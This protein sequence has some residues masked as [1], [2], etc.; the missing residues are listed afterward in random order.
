MSEEIINVGFT[1]DAD[2]TQVSEPLR[3][4]I[5]CVTPPSREQLDRIRDFM[6]A[7]YGKDPSE[8]EFVIKRDPSVVAGFKIFVGDDNYDWSALGRIRQL[9]RSFQSMK[10]EMKE[11]KIIS[12]LREN[13]ENFELG[14]GYQ[15]VGF[16]SSVSNGVVRL[17]GHY[18]LEY[19]E[20][21]LFE[22][23]VKGMVQDIL[24]DGSSGVV[25][26]GDESEVS[27]GMKVLERHF[28]EK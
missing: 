23:G 26:F 21:V 25:L 11:E 15:Q 20:I 17:T 28:F 19:G 16:V 24:S 22:S 13:V 1:E 7:R 4:E 10:R 9:R 27:E 14:T 5:D 3:I 8:T 2:E 6:A 12:L 18:D